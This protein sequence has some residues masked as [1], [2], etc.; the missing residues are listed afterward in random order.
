VRIVCVGGGPAGLY[1]AIL[2]KRI[3]AGHEISVIERKPAE[4]SAGWGVVFWDELLSDLRDTD[5]ETA[6]LIAKSAFQWHGQTLDLRG[7]RM[8]APGFGYSIGRSKLLDILTARA[9]ALGVDIEFDREIN[10]VA[11]L[12]DAD[13]VV[14]CDGMNSTLRRLLADRFG[15]NVVPGRNKYLWLGTPR[16]FGAFTFPFV[17][18][19]AGWIWCHA[20]AFSEDESTF[21]VECSPETW[22]GLGFDTLA[23]RPGLRL[24]EEIFANELDGA[25]L[26]TAGA[27]DAALPWLEFR[28]VTNERWHTGNI[29]LMGDAAHTTHFSIGSGTTLA[30]EDA[31][32]LARELPGEDAGQLQFVAYEA[33]RRAALLHSQTDA[34]LSAQWFEHIDAHIDTSDAAF[35][36][37]LRSRRDPW[38]SRVPSMLYYRVHRAADRFAPLRQLRG[39]VMPR[40]RAFGRHAYRRFH[41]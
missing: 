22:A 20:Y 32:A 34:Q 9:T 31:I 6:D 41:R 37:C 19:H 23:S 1:F 38:T 8:E 7:T 35:F 4:G 21:V 26:E 14:A 17:D 12:P 3:R 13:L 11:E 28:T 27:E 24:L 25:P 29:V 15:T 2:M 16:V 39:W 36:F 10:D 5:P 40:A 30:L 18:T 33:K